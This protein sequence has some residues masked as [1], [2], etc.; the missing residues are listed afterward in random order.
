MNI[1]TKDFTYSKDIMSDD[2]NHF[3]YYTFKDGFGI[4]NDSVIAVYNCEASIPFVV[5]DITSDQKRYGAYFDR[6]NQE[7]EEQGKAFL[8]ILYNDMSK[9]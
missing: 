6:A 8:Q 9:R 1:D 7:I 3:A 2:F 4:L 5:K